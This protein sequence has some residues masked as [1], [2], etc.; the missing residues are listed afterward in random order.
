MAQKKFHEIAHISGLMF[1]GFPGKPQ[2]NKHL[3]ATSSLLY[4]VFSEYEPDS[5]LLQQAYSE[6]MHYQVDDVRL[7]E[8]LFRMNTLPQKIISL[9][10]PTPF[11]FPIIAD[12]LRE[13]LSLS[14][15]ELRERI[16]RMKIM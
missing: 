4:K 2:K 1:K 15:E 13:R 10:K 8:A 9:D 11:N 12:R 7:R 6:V 16:K 3:H 5:L 14:T